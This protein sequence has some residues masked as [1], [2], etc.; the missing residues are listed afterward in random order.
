MKRLLLAGAAVIALAAPAHAQQAVTCVNC[1][2]IAQQLIDYGKQ[3]EQLANEIQTATNTLNTYITLVKDTISLPE[4][5]YTDITGTVTQLESLRTTAS[6]L[7]S[8][9]GDMLSKLNAAEYPVLNIEQRLTFDDNALANALIKAGQA[10][11][12]M[13][14]VIQQQS[15]KLAAAQ[16]QSN[17]AS[18]MTQAMQAS[19]EIAATSAQSIQSQTSALHTVL[20]AMTTSMTTDADRRSASDSLTIAQMKAGQAAACSVATSGGTGL[21]VSWC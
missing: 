10:L 16:T 6:L 9:T 3:L 20:Q 17:G 13:P 8:N 12:S 2:T 7:S 5:V 18:G 4:I 1:S 14:A 21:S 11:D 19:N 15:S